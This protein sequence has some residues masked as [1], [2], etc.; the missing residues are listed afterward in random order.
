[1]L[2]VIILNYRKWQIVPE[3]VD[4]FRKYAGS[5]NYR[6]YIVDNGS[7]NGSYEELEKLYTGV[8]DICMLKLEN[9]LGFSGGNNHGCRK[10]IEDGCDKLL[11]TNSDVV[12]KEYSINYMLDELDVNDGCA[13]VF[14]KVFREDGVTQA[15]ELQIAPYD[16]FYDLICSRVKLKHFVPRNIKRKYLGSLFF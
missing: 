13:L 2:G 7:G 6:I 3:C 1:M 14:P 8:D 16:M 11:I 10:A 12:F 5:I 15:K 4:S 9:N